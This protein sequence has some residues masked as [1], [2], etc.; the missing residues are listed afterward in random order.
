MQQHPNYGP[1]DYQRWTYPNSV[2]KFSLLKFT[3]TSF[4]FVGQLHAVVQVYLSHW[5]Y[6][7]TAS[8]YEIHFMSLVLPQQCTRGMNGL[9]IWL[10]RADAISLT[11]HFQGREA[12]D[13][14]PDK[15]PGPPFNWQMGV[16]RTDKFEVGQ[17][18]NL[19][20]DRAELLWNSCPP[21]Q[22]LHAT[23]W[24]WPPPHH[25]CLALVR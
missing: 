20:K 5:L 4:F 3:K 2:N 14:A 25:Y 13:E 8:A 7:I 12:L 16:D 21:E 19:S 11:K 9:W 22:T 1:K 17:R 24:C 23:A 18:I 15:A 10:Y 6:E